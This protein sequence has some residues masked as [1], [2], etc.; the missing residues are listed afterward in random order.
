METENELCG[1]CG[2]VVYPFSKDIAVSD[3]LSYCV[4]CAEELDRNYLSRN[5]CSVCTKLIEKDEV[6]F[7]MPSRLYSNYF[8]DKLPIE[9]RLMCVNCYR[10]LERLNVLRFPLIKIGQIRLRLMRKTLIRRSTINVK[11]AK[12]LD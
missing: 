6:K 12:V 5:V 10:R 1:R 11:S 4:K 7:V 3:N 9:N 2:T 8:F